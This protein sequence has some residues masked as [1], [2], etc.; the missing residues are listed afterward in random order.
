M[1]EQRSKLEKKAKQEMTQLLLSPTFCVVPWTSFLLG[2]T[3]TNIKMCCYAWSFPLKTPDGQPYSF[4]KH[5]L[6]EIWNGKSMREIRKKML[7]GK[8][9]KNCHTCYEYE[10]KSNN[11]PRN[12]FNQQYLS[13]SS[14]YR[15]IILNKVKNSVENDYKTS[16]PNYLDVRLGNFC[17][18]Q[19]RMCSPE[20]SSKIQKEAEEL[21]EENKEN[22]QYFDGGFLEN[23]KFSQHWYKNPRF[24]ENVY[25]WIPYIRKINFTGGEPTLIKEN[26]EL[27]D[28]IKK[29]GYAKNMS[30]RIFTNST[31]I[32]EKLLDTFNY[33][34]KVDLY[35]SIDGYKKVQ[36]YIRY[37]S[38][39]ETI[40]KN[41][42]YI[43]IKKNKK[44]NV[45]IAPTLQIYNITNIIK[46]LQWVHKL[47]EINEILWHSPFLQ[48]AKKMFD[49]DILPKNIKQIYLNKILNYEKEYQY[50]KN[51]FLKEGLT[52][53]KNIL[54]KLPPPDSKYHLAEFRKYTEMLDK[55]RGNSFQKTF[56]ELYE[57][58][59]EDGSW[60]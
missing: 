28:Y 6:D 21:I 26:W 7:T 17:N 29:N 5:T 39:W 30:L 38:K 32:S 40:E 33:F 27:I 55:K 2:P 60:R 3:G 57:L 10:V 23:A 25:R 53:L 43:L 36:E 9:V 24:L 13:D 51:I 46:L 56:P 15:K 31:Y 19:C 18:L 34:Q 16:P 22:S 4:T 14:P 35:L 12:V 45:F 47:N 54:S 11:S 8:E 1:L 48:V 20:S 58:L 41:T 42:L 52:P 37:P 50:E 59:E 44:T 49:I